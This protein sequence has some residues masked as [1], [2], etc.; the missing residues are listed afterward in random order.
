MAERDSSLT[1]RK[2]DL[3]GR[4]MMLPKLARIDREVFATTSIDEGVFGHP[5]L[6]LSR[7][8]L[9]GDVAVLIVN[10][11]FLFSSSPY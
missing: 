3:S 1:D 8:L 6:I 11:P 9:N 4:I 10:L 5:V 7:V 2:A